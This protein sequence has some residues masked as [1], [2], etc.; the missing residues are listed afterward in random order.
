MLNWLKSLFGGKKAVSAAPKKVAAATDYTS[1][2]KKEL[3]DLAAK[4]GVDVKKS[5]NKTQ[6]INALA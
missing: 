6:I 4:R 1:M 3:M 2:T 5:W